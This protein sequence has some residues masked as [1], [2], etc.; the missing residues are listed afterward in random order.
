MTTNEVNTDTALR[1]TCCSLEDMPSGELY[2]VVELRQR[3]F[4]IEQDC[5]FPDLDGR[6]QDS[7]HLCGWQGEQLLAYL[8]AMPPGLAEP[9]SS[10]GRVVVSPEARGTSLGRELMRR[11]IEVNR[12]RWPEHDIRIGAQAYLQTFYEGLGFVPDSDFY[13]ED[14]ILHLKM[15]LKTS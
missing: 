14:G 4:I 9:G 2:R 11:G 12:E 5:V 15:L 13:D 8:R 3:V 6:D 7:L 1:W 10:L